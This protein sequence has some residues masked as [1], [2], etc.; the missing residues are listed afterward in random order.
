MTILAVSNLSM[1]WGGG[2][3]DTTSTLERDPAYSPTG[4]T[5]LSEN[6]MAMEPWPVPVGDL[7]FHFRWRTGN[8]ISSSG[9]DG[10]VMSF[11]NASNSLVARLDIA[12]GDLFAA[13]YGDSTVTSPTFSIANSSNYTFDI[14]V[15]VGANITMDVYSGGGGFPIMSATVANVGAKTAPVRAVLDLNDIVTS[16]PETQYFSEFIVT[17]S[18][19][20]R[21]WRLATLEPNTNGNYDQW[22]GDVNELG[23]SDSATLV[24]T[25]AGA[26]RQSW[27]PTAYGGPVSPS[28]IRAVIGKSV[29]ARGLAGSPS[30]ITQFL[31]IAAT[32]YDGASQGFSA[33]EQKAIYE[34]W[35]N[36]PNT[37]LPWA[38]ADLATVEMGLLSTT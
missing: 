33:G 32:D 15:S 16:G 17:D 19:D 4:L 9:S 30:Q 13:V 23:D 37:A 26:Q 6:P 31:R 5:T 21:N 25:D 29:C 12:N 2:T 10:Y 27:N 24:S 3:S 18:E 8:I 22:L 38:T 1:D 11:Y 7:W 34:V 20:T 35:D 36:N 14:R 28:S